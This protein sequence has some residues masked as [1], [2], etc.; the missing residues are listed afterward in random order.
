MNGVSMELKFKRRI[1]L[2]LR[3]LDYLRN[4][5][6]FELLIFLN[7][8]TERLDCLPLQYQVL[9]DNFAYWNLEQTGEDYFV[10][11]NGTY[12]YLFS[13]FMFILTYKV[14]Y[15]K[16]SKHWPYTVAHN[17]LCVE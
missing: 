12:T 6:M 14:T 4:S 11:S 17:W 15:S 8:K 9:E 13:S 10:I 5:H 16:Y 3:G 1:L 7:C 2:L